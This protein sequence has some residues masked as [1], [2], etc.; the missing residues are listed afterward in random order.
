MQRFKKIIFFA[1]GWLSVGLA[2]LGVILPVLPTTPF[3]LVAVWAFS[4]SSPA[5]AARI[6]NDRRFG[7]MISDWQDHGRI[8]IFGK[9]AAVVMMFGAAGYLWFYSGLP[10]WLVISVCIIMLGVAGYVVS[11]PSGQ[12]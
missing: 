5:L 7:P 10:L 8:P 12:A 6:R 4:K 9:I 11:R 1:I 3:L 2:V